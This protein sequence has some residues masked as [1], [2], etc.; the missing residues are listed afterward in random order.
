MPDAALAT[1]RERA[2]GPWCAQVIV[3]PK[4]IGIVAAL[5]IGLSAAN[6]DYVITID[7]DDLIT[8]DALQIIAHQIQAKAQPEFLFSDEDMLVGGRPSTPYLR[9]PYDPMLSLDN[10]TIWHLCA[11]KRSFAIGAGV[12]SDAAANWCQDWDSVSRIAGHDG[13]IEHIPE[14]L[15]H[16]RQHSGS[17]TNNPE[18][19]PRQLDSVRHILERHIARCSKASHLEVRE[20]PESRG[21][22]ELY[23]ARKTTNLPEFI[24]YGDVPADG[25]LACTEDAIVVFAN[26][27]VS[28]D[29]GPV[30]LEAAR[31]FD[32]HP[33]AAVLGGNVVNA[34]GVIVDGCYLRNA[35]GD[36][37]APW[38]ARPVGDGGPY[39]L[40]L[41]TQQVDLPGGALAFFRVSAL[42]QVGLWPLASAA[43]PADVVWQLCDD[44]T[45]AGWTVGFSP[46]IRGRLSAPLKLER[47]ARSA[48]SAA[49]SAPRGLV[50]YG[51]SRNFVY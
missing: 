14:V 37:E 18:G 49:V 10:S 4:A 13:R 25:Q 32:L 27:G 21:A 3:E 8:D 19:D 2:A 39:A 28:I 29:S 51:M 1:V 16:W 33:D 34:A 50:R 45:A 38:F 22:R 47:A 43:R 40:A 11:M 36:L 46:L 7:A 5:H 24:W 6:G 26:N 17:T 31:L 44:L 20:W 30:F 15:Y 9:G 41:K 23:I 12:Y 35:N 42:K 48:A